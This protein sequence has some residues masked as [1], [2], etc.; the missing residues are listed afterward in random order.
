MPQLIYEELSNM[1][2]K[3]SDY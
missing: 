2:N 1:N 3:I